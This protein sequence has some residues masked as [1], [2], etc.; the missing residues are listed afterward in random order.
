MNDKYGNTLK[1]FSFKYPNWARIIY[2]LEIDDLDLH[3]DRFT[4]KDWFQ[5][6]KEKYLHGYLM[7]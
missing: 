4:K 6:D 5:L 2:L 1:K 7:L 3:Y